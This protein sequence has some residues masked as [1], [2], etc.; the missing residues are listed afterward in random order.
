MAEERLMEVQDLFDQYHLSPGPLLQVL[1]KF[2][3][4]D[5]YNESTS[6]D[7]SHICNASCR[8]H[9]T[10]FHLDCLVFEYHVNQGQFSRTNFE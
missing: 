3:A 4:N 5:S 6:S 10:R 1:K 9:K 8:S 7:Y 2:I